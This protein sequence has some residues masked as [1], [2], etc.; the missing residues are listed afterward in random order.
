MSERF[1]CVEP[2]QGNLWREG[3]SHFAE[4]KLSLTSGR[5]REECEATE[6]RTV[7]SGS[8]ASQTEEVEQRNV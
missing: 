5:L 6:L 1:L 3:K 2:P 4:S 7:N 8:F